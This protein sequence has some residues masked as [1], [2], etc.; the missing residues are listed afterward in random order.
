MAD[1]KVPSFLVAA[2]KD[3]LSDNLDR[4]QIV[5]G[6]NAY[7]AMRFKIKMPPEVP[8][9]HQERAWTSSIWYTPQ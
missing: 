3:P 9:A 4:I 7:D 8:M 1:K 2:M 5:K 6:W